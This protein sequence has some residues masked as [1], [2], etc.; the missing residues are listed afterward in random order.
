M[1]RQITD[2]GVKALRPKATRYE[3]PIG[4]GL[5]AV[6]QPT[7]RRGFCVRY[8]FAGKPRKLTL[9]AG[10]TLA[11][12]RRE[13]ADARYQVERGVDPA[14]VKRQQR[15]AQ[16]L[17]AEETF[18]VVTASYL[19]RESDRLRSG[20]VRRRDLERLVLPTL[21]Q[22]PIGEIKRSEIIRLLD[23]IEE[24]NGPMMADKTL[25]LIRTI[26]N[27][28]AA[29]SDDFRSPI[30]RGM[31]RAKAKARERV[32]S[33]AELRAVWRTAEA[34]MPNPFAALLRFLLLTAARRAEAGG[35]T[36]QEIVCN[37]W[38]MPA[39]RNKVKVEL[40]RP[41]SAAAHALLSQLP[42]VAGGEFV[43]SIDGRRPLGG[44]SQRKK[45]FDRQSGTSGWTLH[46]LRR[47][48]RSLLSRAGVPSDHA[49]RCLGHV[50]GGMRGVYDRHTF[51]AEMQRAYEALA[52]QI[53]RIAHPQQNVVSMRG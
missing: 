47:T 14:I 49:E 12:A 18:A 24:E 51:I 3:K 38:V 45:T 8:R 48:A 32:L 4:G 29:R 21:G 35:M 41:L 33:D 30:V 31:A 16:R 15:Q 5:Y 17:A 42:H 7:G 39:R 9:Q 6:V 22:R 1:A 27:W 2:I 53:D 11:G 10:I 40:V 50:I 37:E 46:D 20:V 52:V 36:W 23:R 28:H 26:M 25:A 44:I 19:R 13:A 34:N 43:F